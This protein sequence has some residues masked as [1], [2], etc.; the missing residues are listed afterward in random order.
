MP[1]LAKEREAAAARH[2]DLCPNQWPD[3]GAARSGVE[4]RH[5]VEPACV[6]EAEHVMTHRGGGVSEVF[7]EGRGAEEGEGGLGV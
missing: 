6:G 5:A 3:A 4:A 7:G 2:F 1:V